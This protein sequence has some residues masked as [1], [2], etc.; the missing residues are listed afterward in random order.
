MMKKSSKKELE[1]QDQPTTPTFADPAGPRS[2][3]R[4]FE[5][6]AAVRWI[7]ECEEM[8][9]QRRLLEIDWKTGETKHRQVRSAFGTAAILKVDPDFAEE[10]IREMVI[11]HHGQLDDRAIQRF[12]DYAYRSGGGDRAESALPVPR[13]ELDP[14]FVKHLAGR[15]EGVD[16]I[17]ILRDRSDLEPGEVD[18]ATIL[19]ILYRRGEKVLVFDDRMSQGHLVEP[20]SEIPA[21]LP[22]HAEDGIFFLTNPVDGKYHPN[23]R[24]DGKRSR[25]SEESITEFRYLLLESDEVPVEEW[26]RIL[27]QLPLPIAAVYSSGGR[28][29]H[30][31]VRIDVRS[32]RDHDLVVKRI[33]PLLVALG[34][35]Q[36]AMLAVQMSRLPT[37][38]RGSRQQKLLYIKEHPEPLPIIDLV[39]N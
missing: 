5:P 11:A 19:C 38:Y 36:N 4:R 30:S 18:L 25:R 17:E 2:V 35:D 28:S 23:P 22:T 26:L 34:A 37:A 32:K 3:R 8:N 21:D 39:K 14:E 12:R 29:I 20:W 9:F 7:R 15:L 24:E 6:G 27:V 33:K 31:L 16:A 10:R 1:N 13:A